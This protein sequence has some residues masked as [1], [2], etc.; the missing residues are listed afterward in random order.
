MAQV[1]FGYGIGNASGFAQIEFGGSSGLDRA[2]IA[3]AGADIPQNHDGRGAPRPAFAH[4]WALGALANSV[5]LIVV[6]HLAHGS[7]TL[8]AR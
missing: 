5:Q 2:E 1:H 8:A 4:V 3:G 7:V 6:D